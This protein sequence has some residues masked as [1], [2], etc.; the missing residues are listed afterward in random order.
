[1]SFVQ[2]R[3]DLVLIVC[4]LYFVLVLYILNINRGVDMQSRKPGQWFR[5]ALLKKQEESIEESPL[6]HQE[7][8]LSHQ[9]ER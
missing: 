4:S 3:F 7:P 2:S 1:M 5:E 6:S 8:P 9:E